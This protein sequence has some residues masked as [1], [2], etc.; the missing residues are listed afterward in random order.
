[1]SEP[2]ILLPL[3]G[4]QRALNAL[5]VAKVFAALDGAPLRILH[6]TDRPPP[7]AELAAQLGVEPVE[8]RG[9]AIESRP[10]E[11]ASVILAVAQESP[12]RMIV[13][14]THTKPAAPPEVLGHTALAVLRATPCPVVLVNPELDLAGWRLRRVLLPH[15]G[16]PATS[17]ALR[18]GAEFART[19]DAELIVLQVAEAGIPVPAESGSLTPPAYLDQPQ[20]EWPAWGGEFLERLACICPLSGL[21]VRLLLG[22]GAPAAEILRVA[23]EQA[24][25]LVV[26]AWKGR[27]GPERAATL[28]AVVAGGPCPILVVRI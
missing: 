12:A 16:T 11:P 27:W 21:R 10:G 22:R 26:L 24:A 9:A 14:N 15:E 17:D 19:A 25:D 4:S 1:M 5:P 23:H 18:P 6:V 3:D 28:R 7:L 8:L 13:M 20:H 2:V